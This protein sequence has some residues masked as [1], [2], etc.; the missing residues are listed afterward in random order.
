VLLKEK[1]TE[2]KT[3]LMMLKFIDSALSIVHIVLISF[4]LFGWIWP[5]TRKLHL[6]CII[7]TAASW[8]LLGIWF[9]WGYCPIT[10]W[11]WQ[12]KRRLGEHDLPASFIKYFA[13]KIT[14][15]EFSPSLVNWV[16][17]SLFAMAALLSVYVNFWTRRKGIEDLK[18]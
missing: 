18:I 12:I 15:H 1:V 3:S 6:I 14:G 11:Q 13:D 9:G 10:D 5:K 8:F 4:N 7:A 17:V 16:T 2:I